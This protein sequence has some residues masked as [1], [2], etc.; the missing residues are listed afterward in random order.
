MPRKF[1]LRKQ[2]VKAEMLTPENAEELAEWCGG[3]VGSKANFFN[4]PQ[5]GSYVT[6]T[7]A[8][9]H[10]LTVIGEGDYLV[11]LPNGKFDR[12]NPRLFEH[13]YEEVVEEPPAQRENLF[14]LPRTPFSG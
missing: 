2:D 6:L 4:A 10:G 5:E 11:E 13:M 8:G 3:S 12:Y 14:D 9:V 7:L 1:R